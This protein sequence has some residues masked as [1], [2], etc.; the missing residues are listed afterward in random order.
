LGLHEYDESRLCFNSLLELQKS[1]LERMDTAGDALVTD[2]EKAKTDI[3]TTELW[4]KK[5]RKA[6][7]SYKNR[8]KSIG[9]RI[10]KGLFEGKDESDNPKEKEKEKETTNDSVILGDS[11]QPPDELQVDTPT[12]DALGPELTKTV[13]AIKEGCGSEG[14]Q[15]ARPER[16]SL[17]DTLRPSPGPA[18]PGQAHSP[19]HTAS[20][21]T[22][23]PNVHPVI[24]NLHTYQ[25]FYYTAVFVASIAIGL[26]VF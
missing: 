5:L 4:L 2:V 9:K 1:A 20:S 21:K 11:V 25:L 16:E 3:K 17:C 22:K 14:T 10:S 19:A 15:I 12:L 23:R 7:I 8:D 6:E 18:T 13:A 26:K 24:Q